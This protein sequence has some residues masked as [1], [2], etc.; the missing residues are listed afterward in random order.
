MKQY[1]KP[2]KKSFVSVKKMKEMIKCPNC[3]EGKTYG[4]FHKR[5]E[6]EITSLNQERDAKIKQDTASEKL[7]GEEKANIT[8]K[9]EAEFR[10][11]IGEKQRETPNIIGNCSYC[12][13]Q[14][15]RRQEPLPQDIKELIEVST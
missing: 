7:K 3:K 14:G 12:N 2:Y 8:K 15:E 9:I 11:L 1:K 6:R 13:G 4:G 10:E 5:I